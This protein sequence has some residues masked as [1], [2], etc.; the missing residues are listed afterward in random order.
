MNWLSN[1]IPPSIRSFVSEQKEVPDNLWQK[2]TSCDGML[3]HRDLAIK[4]N[5]C[6]HCGH[7]LR[8]SVA[9]RLEMMFDNGE[10]QKHDLPKVALDPLKFKDRKRYIDRIKE[11]QSKTGL[12]E[13][14]TI[15]SGKMGDLVIEPKLTK[16]QFTK[17]KK[18]SV[19]TYFAGRRITINYINPKKLD[20]GK[21]KI[22]EIAINGKI[23]ASVPIKRNIFLKF[24]SKSSNIINVYLSS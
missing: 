22:S 8:F 16:E 13:A 1:L 19:N 11:A 5:V 9:D 24:S 6:Y 20:Y 17:F 12:E 23:V 4:H 7:H 2:C 3:F 21:Y 14:I 15:A 18:I 10:Y